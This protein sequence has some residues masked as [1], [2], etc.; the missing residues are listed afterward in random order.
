M[1]GSLGRR[2]RAHATLI[3]AM[4][5][6][7]LHPTES[8][9]LFEFVVV[10]F[11]A[12]DDRIRSLR[13][14]EEA[15]SILASLVP[16]ENASCTDVC[17]AHVRRFADHSTQLEDDTK[18]MVFGSMVGRGVDQ[19]RVLLDERIVQRIFQ[20]PAA[21]DVHSKYIGAAEISL[22]PALVMLRA[23]RMALINVFGQLSRRQ[24]DVFEASGYDFPKGRILVFDFVDDVPV[25]GNLEF[26]CHRIPCLD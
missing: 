15:A 21:V 20:T 14:E 19:E 4:I 9:D 25:H 12:E 6:H 26:V 5:G 10:K 17:C 13:T 18:A 23:E 3:G 1:L 8:D 22:Q 24:F 16:T 11:V 2:S 7:S